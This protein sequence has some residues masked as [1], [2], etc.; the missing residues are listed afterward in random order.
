LPTVC[1][2]ATPRAGQPC[3]SSDGTDPVPTCTTCWGTEATLA[4]P[5]PAYLTSGT[6]TTYPNG[7]PKNGYC[8]CGSTG[9]WTCASTTAWP[10]GNGS[11]LGGC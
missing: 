9:S 5:S 7:E 8:T 6:T 4:T 2:T 10:C 11:T 1:P 3:T